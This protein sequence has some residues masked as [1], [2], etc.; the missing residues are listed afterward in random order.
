MTE[1]LKKLSFKEESFFLFGSLPDIIGGT[2]Q[3]YRLL[4]SSGTNQNLCKFTELGIRYFLPY[5][6]IAIPL[7]QC[8][9][10]L[11]L[12]CYFFEFC[13]TLFAIRYLLLATSFDKSD[14]LYSSR[15][16]KF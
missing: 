5:S 8:T 3:Y 7:L 1:F 12:L 11:S 6:L 10:L 14:G 15:L 4:V 16:F 13:N 2:V 9:I